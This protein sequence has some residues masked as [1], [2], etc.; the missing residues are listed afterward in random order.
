M[1]IDEKKELNIF[2][3]I[4]IHKKLIIENSKKIIIFKKKSV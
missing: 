2:N 3:L 4:S 1:L